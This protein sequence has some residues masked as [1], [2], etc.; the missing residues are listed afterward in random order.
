MITYSED[1]SESLSLLKDHMKFA[2]VVWEESHSINKE[3]KCYQMLNFTRCPL[4]AGA[5]FV[6]TTLH[7]CGNLAGLYFL[8]GSPMP[9]LGAPYTEDN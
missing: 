8:I 2:G 9:T 6:L 1:T 3:R 5:Y 7:G 4:M